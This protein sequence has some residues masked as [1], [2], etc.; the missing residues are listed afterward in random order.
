MRF[1]LLEEP[2]V[3]LPD[4]HEFQLLID[5]KSSLEQKKEVALKAMT[6]I[7][8]QACPI[9]YQ[10]QDVTN[11]NNSIFKII[12]LLATEYNQNSLVLNIYKNLKL[13]KMVENYYGNVLAVLESLK[14]IDN[15]RIEKI[16]DIIV[17]NSFYMRSK[18]EFDYSFK[19]I[20]ALINP[21]AIKKYFKDPSVVKIEDLLDG[22]EL[23]PA[24]ISPKDESN[25]SIYGVIA[26]WSSG[27]S[28]EEKNSNQSQ[29]SGLGHGSNNDGSYVSFEEADMFAK[30][31]S[32]NR[33]K[34]DAEFVYDPSYDSKAAQH[35][36]P[37]FM[38]RK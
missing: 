17:S 20:S 31:A 29:K 1:T 34:I 4:A 16:K 19:I 22:K 23:K 32:G 24:G 25:G 27:S 10:S 35:W 13:N 28:G 26:S 30:K 9:T 37:V 36:R 6:S 18:E 11:R 38:R 5:K 14:N 3:S 12:Y 15:S 8:M 2:T 21:I 7:N 33:I